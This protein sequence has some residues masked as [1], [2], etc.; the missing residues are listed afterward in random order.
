MTTDPKTPKP[1]YQL[2]G[3][4]IVDDHGH[5]YYGVWRS[6]GFC[7][8]S[9]PWEESPARDVFQDYCS[10]SWEDM[11]EWDSFLPTLELARE[12]QV[13]FR[14]AGFEFGII[15]IYLCESAENVATIEGLPGYLGLDVSTL[16]PNSVLRGIHDDIDYHH[17]PEGLD[18]LWALPP[19]YFRERVNK[20][21]LLTCYEDAALLRD[22][23]MALEKIDTT[24]QTAEGVR[25]LGVQEIRDESS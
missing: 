4:P 17:D 5:V 9:T 24:H 21:G 20:W 19:I 2:V 25:V 12:F 7:G 8:G 10:V 11:G 14:E 3:P 13:R 15:A 23:M 1:V 18:V 6:L 22:V 16:E